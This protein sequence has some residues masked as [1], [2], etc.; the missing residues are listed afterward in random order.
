MT[1]KT[2]KEWLPML[3][4]LGNGI[5]PQ[6]SYFVACSILLAEGRAL[7]ADLTG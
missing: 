3:K 7:P 5:L 1:P 6:Q 2:Y 4:A